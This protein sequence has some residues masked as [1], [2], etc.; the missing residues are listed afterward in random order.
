MSQTFFD[1]S[2]TE[3]DGSNP[4]C[5]MFLPS[6]ELQRQAQEERRQDKTVVSG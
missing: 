4:A 1:G 6:G 5:G 2:S 3:M